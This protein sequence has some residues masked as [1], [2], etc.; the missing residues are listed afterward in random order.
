VL[1][2]KVQTS[3]RLAELHRQLKNK[4]QQ[5][6]RYFDDSEAEKQIVADLMHHL[7]REGRPPIPGV[8]AKTLPAI[9][10]AGDIIAAEETP[11]GYL[12][13]MLADATGHG[14]VA[15]MNVLPAVETFYEMTAKGYALPRTIRRINEVLRELIPGHRFVSALF[16]RIDST[17]GT[18][19]VWNAGIPN[20]FLVDAEGH[21]L[22]IFGPKLLP[23]GIESQD[24]L[25][26]EIEYMVPGQMLVT[27]SD[28]LTE[29]EDASG[30]AFGVEGFVAA[31]PEA[32][33]G[34]C[35]S[36]LARLRAYSGSSVFVD[37]VSVCIVR[38]PQP[39]QLR[40][41]FRDN[42]PPASCR[43]GDI[44]FAMTYG[45]D[46]LRQIVDVVPRF[47][48]L[49]KSQ[50]DL[51][52]SG[53]SRLFR[54]VRQLVGNAIDW[55]MLRLPTTFTQQSPTALKQARTA[56]L[57]ELT[58]GRLHMGIHE[59][60]MQQGGRVWEVIIEDSGPGF[61][62]AAALERAAAAQPRP[63]GLALVA[64]EVIAIHFDAPGNRVRVWVPE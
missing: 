51:P 32:A 63:G 40:G 61:D 58:E 7:R 19:E 22:H 5:L 6:Q 24:Y 28:G 42:V 14:L 17:L 8:E 13:L 2:S 3:Q 60:P 18:I 46:Q 34:G 48:A 29:A 10:F 26:S 4:T 52:P 44:G 9:D 54:V 21:V 12:H 36:V 37:D 41:R 38:Q 43:A 57:A 59:C 62:G 35:D 16:A 47:M 55:G 49:A 56:A 15:A 33:R 1:R 50:F 53:Y 25:E 30:V 27:A 20:A 31:L 39:P 23:L 45:A 64:D 11:D